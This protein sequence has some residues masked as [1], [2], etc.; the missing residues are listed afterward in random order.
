[1]KQYVVLRC[2]TDVGQGSVMNRHIFR[3]TGFVDL[4]MLCM[5]TRASLN[6]LKKSIL[7]QGFD[8]VMI[9]LVAVIK[10]DV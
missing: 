8:A 4:S 7:Q 10:I 9:L 3:P 1:M 5:P 2:Y 6:W